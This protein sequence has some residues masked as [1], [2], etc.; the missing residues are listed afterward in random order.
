MFEKRKTKKQSTV[1]PAQT[2]A[3]AQLNDDLLEAVAGGTNS[4][5]HC[6]VCGGYGRVWTRIGEYAPGDAS[7]GHGMYVMCSKCGGKS[8]RRVDVRMISSDGDIKSL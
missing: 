1:K 6:S 5:E 7:G 2:K 4:E 3:G 8:T